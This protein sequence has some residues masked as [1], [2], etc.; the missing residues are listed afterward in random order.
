MTDWEWNELF[1]VFWVELGYIDIN[2]RTQ[3]TVSCV[4][5][6]KFIREQ[7]ESLVNLDVL[8]KP[9]VIAELRKSNTNRRIILHHDNASSHTAHQTTEYLRHKNGELLD[10]PPY[11]PDLSPNDFFTFPKIKDIM[12]SRRF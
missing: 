12:R 3:K 6:Y 1:S 7:S 11:S 8:G 4:I 10:H 2:K 9:H 5:L